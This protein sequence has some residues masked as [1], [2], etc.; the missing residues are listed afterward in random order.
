MEPYF[1]SI[2]DL[3]FS[4][5][6]HKVFHHFSLDIP[7]QNVTI[8]DNTSSGKTTLL[9]LL[10]GELK[11][12]RGAITFL[13]KRSS[14]FVF[15]NLSFDKDTVMEEFSFSLEEMHVNP[16]KIE[17]QI[18]VFAASF[19]IKKL[20]HQKIA[21][22][23]KEEQYFIKILCYLIM[24]PEV[25]FFDNVLSHLRKEQRKLIFDY[26]K[27]HH[28]LFINVTSNIEDAMI[29]DYLIILH[30]GSVA[31]EGKPLAVFGEEKLLRRLGYTLPFQVDL[32]TQLKYYGLLQTNYL[33]LE[34]ME[35]LLW[36]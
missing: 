4:Y 22:L 31:I 29:S 26:L 28:I 25:I 14:V 20:L 10:A 1:I 36:K 19:D 21:L 30:E 15:E 12:D 34:E 8:M 23:D 7:Y 16:K 9:H 18:Y 2:K 3:S 27:E 6:V 33:P 11:A 35:E 24:Q 5:P 17:E 13:S 32:C